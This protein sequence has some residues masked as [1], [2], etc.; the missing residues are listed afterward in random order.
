[1]RTALLILS[2]LLALHLG[3]CASGSG[4][5]AAVTPGSRSPLLAEKLTQ[6]AIAELDPTPP[7][8]PNPA[9]AEQLLKDALAA[10]LF[11][12]PAHNNLGALYLEQGRL[13]EAASEFDWACK[14]MPGHPDPRLNLAMTLEHA[15]R[16]DEA[17]DEYATALAV[18]PNHMP[19]LQ[20]MT[21]CEIKHSRPTDHT[22]VH[23]REIALAG[24]DQT[25][26]AW[27]QQQ[28]VK[29]RGAGD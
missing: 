3:G 10:D 8:K 4:G 12:G 23:L 19:T 15:G 16:V 20:A 11:H 5:P 17:L 9:K 6:Q 7:D 13:Y 25:W 2:F 21:R 14:L 28:L 29:S 18:Y 26:R 22:S 24:E 27:A 1:M